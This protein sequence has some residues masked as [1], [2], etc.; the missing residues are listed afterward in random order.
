MRTSFFT[1]LSFLLTVVIL[2]TLGA[3]ALASVPQVAISAGIVEG[4]RCTGT[5][6]V[7]YYKSIPYA[8]PP[9]G[10]LRFAPPQPY[11]GKFPSGTLSATSSAPAC[12]QFGTLFVEAGATS[13]DWSVPILSLFNTLGL[14]I[15]C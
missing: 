7:V 3:T 14:K 6:D 15:L 2:G 9:I 8:Q 11:S 12:I 10:D 13:E 5:S 4:G 1:M